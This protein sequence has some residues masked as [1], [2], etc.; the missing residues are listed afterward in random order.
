M[1][2]LTANRDHAGL[3]KACAVLWVDVTA[4]R[5]Y[6]TG[7]FGPSA[8][9][10]SFTTDDDLPN[11][12]AYAETCALV[13]MIFWTQQMLANLCKPGPVERLIRLRQR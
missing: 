13:E 11:D 5:M 4:T 10:E 9:D 12:T 7:G 2:D 1:A 6:V 8:L 3:T